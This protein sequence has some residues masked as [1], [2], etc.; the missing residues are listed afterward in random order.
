MLIN[1][2]CSIKL[3]KKVFPSAFPPN[4]N[5]NNNNFVRQSVFFMFGCPVKHKLI[6]FLSLPLPSPPAPT[7]LYIQY[8]YCKD[9]GPDDSYKYSM[10][11]GKIVIDR[12]KGIAI[13]L[14]QYVIL[15]QLQTKL[16]CM[17]DKKTLS[18]TSSLSLP[19]SGER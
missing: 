7:V 17:F 1:I 2:F 19:Y 11:T 10:D 6:E 9:Q 12:K 15:N 18:R 14:G 3:I 16:L 8:Q 5:N 4:N 13:T